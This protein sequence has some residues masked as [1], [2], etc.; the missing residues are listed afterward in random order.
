[1]T[2]VMYCTNTH[3]IRMMIRT[4]YGEGVGGFSVSSPP[5]TSKNNKKHPVASLA[6][7]TDIDFRRLIIWD[8]L[9]Y[10]SKE[11]LLYWWT[12]WNQNFTWRPINRSTINH[13]IV[14]SSYAFPLIFFLV[15]F[16][17]VLGPCWESVHSDA[18][19]FIAKAQQQW[20]ASFYSSLLSWIF[21]FTL[22]GN[23]QTL[24][25]LDVT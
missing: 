10:F 4:I 23:S 15:F 17:A 14:H 21:S 3:W 13:F 7:M 9:L 22:T 8:Q 25:C 16:F 18:A 6:Q 20:S 2:T 5:V 11:K 24:V 19:Q 1:M 12:F